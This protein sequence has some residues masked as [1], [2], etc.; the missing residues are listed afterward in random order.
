MVLREVVS[1][2]NYTE[3]SLYV[4]ATLQICISWVVET[5][6]S[7]ETK[8]CIKGPDSEANIW[9]KFT[10]ASGISSSSSPEKKTIDTKLRTR[11]AYVPISVYHI[12]THLLAVLLKASVEYSA[13]RGIFLNTIIIYLAQFYVAKKGGQPLA[14]IQNCHSQPETIG[15][16]PLR[17]TDIQSTT[18]HILPWVRS[19]LNSFLPF[20]LLFPS[21][22]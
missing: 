3:K 11:I 18:A 21:T 7:Q 22:F 5:W 9:H 17:N 6:A 1:I 2:D 19:E 12:Y 13:Q 15:L 20:F 16:I 8:T 14:W 4:L 10:K